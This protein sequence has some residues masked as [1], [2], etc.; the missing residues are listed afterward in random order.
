[1]DVGLGESGDGEEQK[2][3]EASG[4]GFSWFAFWEL[5]GESLQLT[6]AKAGATEK[7]KD[8]S[9]FPSGMTTKEQ[10]KARISNGKS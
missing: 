10:N 8:R 5:G 6:K 3:Q 7:S 1:V 4:H 9:R 2:E